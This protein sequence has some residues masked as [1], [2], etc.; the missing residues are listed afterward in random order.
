MP[1]TVI[2]KRIIVVCRETIIFFL[3]RTLFNDNMKHQ[4]IFTTTR[5]WRQKAKKE[6]RAAQV[7][8][9]YNA[10]IHCIT[11]SLFFFLTFTRQPHAR[12]NIQKVIRI[13]D[14]DS[15]SKNYL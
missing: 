1:S 7:I 5:R 11:R 13:S 15:E 12:I 9:T 8:Y 6:N 10:N 4:T 2:L 14:V 3:F